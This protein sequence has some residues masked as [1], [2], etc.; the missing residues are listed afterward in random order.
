MGIVKTEELARTVEFPLGERAVAKRSW[1]CTLDDNTLQ[2][3]PLTET[4]VFAAV[5]VS[6]WYDAHPTWPGLYVR[7][8]QITER[9]ADSPY[10]VEVV[11]E[12]GPTLANEVLAPTSRSAEWTFESQ[13]SQ[14][15]ALYYYHGTGNNDLRPLVNSA[16]DYFEGLTTEESMVRATIR[17]NFSQFPVSQMSATNSIN[18]SLYFSCP[19]YTWKC[20]GVNSAYT[21]E[22]H[23][24]TSYT[25]W[26]T[27]MELCYR[28][29]GWVLQL[30]DVGWNFLDGGVKRRA[31]V[32]DEK[33]AEWV[34]SANPVGLNGSGQQTL[35]QPAILQRRVNTSADFTTLFGTPPT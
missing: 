33:N 31:M 7:K 16:Y 26:A 2:N 35:G 23:N 9:H 24:N 10:H 8:F 5:G 14:V 25:Y 19:A 3:N 13:P 12:Y 32:F 27:Q 15:P 28:Q 34:A 4:D 17:K 21:I 6:T 11:A 30:P 22:L 29:T 1:V 18:A 20:V